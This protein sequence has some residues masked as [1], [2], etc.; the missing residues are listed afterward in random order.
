RL[1]QGRFFDR[2][3]R[4]VEEYHEK[5]NTIHLHRVKTGLVSKA[6]EW[7]WWSVRDYTGS[8]A[9]AAGAE[10]DLAIDRVLLPAE[11]TARI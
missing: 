10:R 4:T 6:E 7:K 8:V 1:W 3:L 2:A 5:V 9:T 11:G